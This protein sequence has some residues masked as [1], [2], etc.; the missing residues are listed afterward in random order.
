A[1]RLADLALAAGDTATVR[2]AAATAQLADEHASDTPYCDLIRAAHTEGN[3]TE[4]YAVIDGLIARRNVE[5]EE[6]LHPDT[7]ELINK[8]APHWDSRNHAG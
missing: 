6:D 1:H 8:L 5:L 7:Y 3:T 4:M 2:W